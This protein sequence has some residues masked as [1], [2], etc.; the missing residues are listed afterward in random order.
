MSES[1]RH[2][3]I[4][5]IS[6]T[7]GPLYAEITGAIATAIRNG[8]LMP[9]DR[10]PPHREMARALSVDLT[11]VTRAYAGAQKLG[12]IEATA[13]RGTFVR[14]DLAQTPERL[15]ANS[16]IDMT[17]N[18]PPQPDPG[19]LGGRSLPAMLNEGLSRLL[20]HQDAASLLTYRWGAIAYDECEAG[21]AWIRPCH[22]VPDARAV[23]VCPGAQTALA[24][25]FTLHARRGD[26][27][28]CERMAYPGLRALCKHL[29]LQLVGV[30]T[31][32][33]GIRP[34]ALEAAIRRDSP[35]L[36]YCNPTINN[37]TTATMGAS[38]R[39]AIAAV[40]RRADTIFVED[41]A[42]GLLPE[43]KQVSISSLAPARAYYLVTMAKTLSPSLR[44]AYLA[45][46]G[47]DEARRTC[48]ALRANA[49]MG[50]GIL[51]ALVASWITGGEAA[52]VLHAIRK[53]AEARQKIAASLL[54]PNLTAADPFGHHVWLTIQS[55]WTAPEFVSVAKDKGLALVPAANF[56]VGGP[57]Q[58]A[59]RIALGSAPDRTTLSQALQS[60][61]AIL[62]TSPSQSYAQ[63]V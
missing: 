56:R 40:L 1:S 61:S 49:L 42:Y 3:W 26:T 62:E 19:Q 51:S 23:L 50:S 41:D 43:Q 54:P 7:A 31:D 24:T 53:E 9:G 2:A 60:I 8:R 11:T 12:L 59:V 47:V 10:L 32:G 48:A 57:P 37:P 15:S 63:V 4:P 33:E 38:R 5:A 20:R 45:T 18:V 6:R 16:V 34:D 17:M 25:L 29:G 22:D 58:E 14:S 35:K 28:L 44:I 21:A 27:V 36:I 13:G 46:P 52:R 39:E 30:E 55:A